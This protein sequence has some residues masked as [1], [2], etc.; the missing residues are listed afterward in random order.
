MRFLS[1][2]SRMKTSSFGEVY[3]HLSKADLKT[4]AFLNSPTPTWLDREYPFVPPPDR[5]ATLKELQFLISLVSEREENLE[6]IKQAD[7][8][9]SSLFEDLCKE[10]GTPYPEQDISEIISESAIWITKLKWLYNRPRP[11]Q[12][13][14]KLGISFSPMPSKTA[15]TP[16]YPGGHTIQ[17]Y[18]VADLLSDRAPQHRELFMDLASRISWSRALGGYHWPSDL[19]FGKSLFQHIVNEGMPSS[20]RVAAKFKKKREVPRSDGKGTTTIYEYSDRQIANRHKE[21]AKRI[22]SLRQKMSDLRATARKDLDSEDPKTRLTALAVCL[23]DETYERVGNSGSAENGHFGVTTWKVEHVK[24]SPKKAVITYVG[25]SGVEQEKEI[26]QP[27]VLA[28]LKK[29]LEGKKGSDNVFCEGED[30]TVAAKDVNEYLRSYDVTAKDIRGLHA[31]EEMKRNLKKVRSEGGTLPK[32]KKEREKALKEE[33]KKA[34]GLSAEAVGHEPATLRG[35]YLVPGMEEEYLMGGKVLDKL[36]KKAALRKI[37]AAQ[38]LIAT[39]SDSEKEDREAERLVQQSP[40][41][42]PPRNDLRRNTPQDEEKDPDKEQDKKDRS[43]NYKDA[44]AIRVALMWVD[45]AAKSKKITVRR[46]EDGKVVQVSERTLRE[47]S[48]DYEEIE[49]D[50]AGEAPE[51]TPSE[52]TPEEE[53]A[54]EGGAAP[55]KPTL[56]SVRSNLMSKYRDLG[57][58]EADINETLDK[59]TDK[60]LTRG[61]RAAERALEEKAS[62]SEN[63][64]RMKGGVRA[65]RQKLTE[66]NSE[67]KY[68]VPA[69]DLEK[70]LRLVQRGID[71]AELDEIRNILETRS[72]QI[73]SLAETKKALLKSGINTPSALKNFKEKVQEAYAEHGLEDDEIEELIEHLSAGDSKGALEEAL[74]SLDSK[75]SEKARAKEIA[76]NQRVFKKLRAEPL[77]EALSVI[78][79]DGKGDALREYLSGLPPEDFERFQKTLS[80]EFA[81]LQN[82]GVEDLEGY[83]RNLKKDNESL[84]ASTG[85]IDNYQDPVVLGKALARMKFDQEIF[86]SPTYDPADPIP[87]ANARPTKHDAEK[88]LARAE[89]AVEKY[90]N[91]PKEEREEHAEKLDHEIDSLPE[92]SPRRLHL[93]S[94]KKG[95]GVASALTDG[96]DAEGIGGSTA[97]LILAADKGGNLKKILSLSSLSGSHP[98]GDEQAAIE[99]SRRDQELIREVFAGI[100]D[101]DWLEMIPEDHPGRGWAELLGP[102]AGRFMNTQ[103]RKFV[104]Q[105][106]SDLMLGEFSIL[107]RA[108]DEELDE[109]ETRGRREEI[110]RAARPTAKPSLGKGS[111]ISKAADWFSNFLKDLAATAKSKVQSFLGAGSGKKKTKKKTPTKKKPTTKGKAPRKPRRAPSSPTP[112]SPS[113][114]SPPSPSPARVASLHASKV[115]VFQTFALREEIPA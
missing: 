1:D 7:E 114:P 97:R 8:D 48:G 80:Q 12:I 60:N 68:P 109:D 82:D 23:M 85:K 54:P 44:T 90:R 18:L 47:R 75:V 55:E 99:E 92:G 9:F 11:F 53:T 77:N 65:I 4:L 102:N 5:G 108:I 52:E 26:T 98:E 104:R 31:N 115:K 103:D 25:K 84:A 113:P 2:T 78:P 89:R 94:L 42:K 100:S 34:L 69:E 106:L 29:A 73:K 41:K 36:D 72:N 32:D 107:D 49:E 66:Q 22:E 70:T 74:T 33:F 61:S 91:M 96:L 39:L 63:L 59:I 3:Q 110:A 95:I 40:K 57:L 88:A 81:A 101:D 112:P 35:Q 37:L 13:A 17:A 56:E 21:K 79:E 20:V 27:K 6:F 10:I 45:A 15:H 28:A 93:E 30:C 46:K 67:S 86:S 83:Q 24:V 76:E 19:I 43:N 14:E 62:K 51:E 38:G 64:L 111:T 50:E 105:A 87:A 71:P 16:A 58:T